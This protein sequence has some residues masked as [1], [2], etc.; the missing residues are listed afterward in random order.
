MSNGNYI[1]DD[2]EEIVDGYVKIDRYNPG[3]IQSISKHYGDILKHLG[4]DPNREGLI[5]TP[6][7][8]AKALLY[9]THG[10]DLDPQAILESAK[11]REDYSQ[12]VVVKDI[13]I[14]SMCEHHLL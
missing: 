11:F 10:Y 14:Y 2:D 4:E 3:L 7:R 12:M 9:L 6:E 5:K 13:E 1:N 8:I